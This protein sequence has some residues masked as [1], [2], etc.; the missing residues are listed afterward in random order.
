MNRSRCRFARAVLAAS[1]STL[2]V[3]HS[4]VAAQPG[5]L[6]QGYYE[7]KTPQGKTV[8][9]PT[10]ADGTAP[11]FWWDHLATRAKALREAGFT[12]VWL[13]PA[14]KGAS[15]TSSVGF[16]LFDDYD[17]GS[18]DQKGTIP[19]RY[20]TREQLE[21]C[22][23]ILRANGIDVYLDTVENQRDGGEGPGGFTF[24]YADAFGKVGD[25][26]FPKFPDCFHHQGIPEDPDVP[27]P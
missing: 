23:A 3:A 17:L 1:L 6:L 15:G 25:G 12:A 19:T 5:V 16:D 21:R 9:V 2:L 13:P 18:K 27:G 8:G 10:K 14:W 4:P 24:R 20:G 22:V 7:L 11:D 26:R